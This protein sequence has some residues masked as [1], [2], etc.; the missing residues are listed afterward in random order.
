MA[1]ITVWLLISVGYYGNYGTR[2][3]ERFASGDECQRVL[4][5]T[6]DVAEFGKPTLRCIQ[7]TVMKEKQ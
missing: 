3:V 4:L 2:V 7:A 1:T 6:R 5:L